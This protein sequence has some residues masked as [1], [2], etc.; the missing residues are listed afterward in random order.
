MNQIGHEKHSK[1]VKNCNNKK[2]QQITQ[3]AQ[4]IAP[5]YFHTSWKNGYIIKAG[6]GFHDVSSVAT[7]EESS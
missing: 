6:E 5:G 1:V 3:K 2:R 7:T 4:D